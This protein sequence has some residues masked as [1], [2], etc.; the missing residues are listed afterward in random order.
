MTHRIDRMWL[1]GGIVVMLLLVAGSW[2]LLIAPKNAEADEVRSSAA[3]ATAQLIILK[4]QVAALKA[5]SAKLDSYKT[6][7]QTNQK[8][9]P[10]TS[11]VPDFL[12]QLQD[13]GTA[14]DVDISN[15]SVGA[16]ELTK[17]VAGVYQLPI[18]LSAAGTVAD[19]SAFLNR[20]QQVQPRA[21]LLK[22]VGLT[23]STDVATGATS[24]QTASISLLAF[25]SPPSG[26]G[27]PTVTTN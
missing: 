16:P 20:L 2:F 11:G 10:T 8:A 14:V 13:S 5:E 6:Q 26:A 18:S 1:L 27:K 9:L 21:V 17:D 4:H 22:S 19:M 3:D 15:V 23:E 24:M 7:L 12:R 25:V